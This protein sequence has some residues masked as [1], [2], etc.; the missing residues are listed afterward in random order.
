MENLQ[1]PELF[2]G[3]VAPVGTDLKLLESALK[4]QLGT[5]TYRLN[6]IKLIQHVIE[7]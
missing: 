6:R 7:E 3:L 1:G 5:V 4:R 2:L